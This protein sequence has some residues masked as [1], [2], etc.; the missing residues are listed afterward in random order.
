M[1]A[2]ARKL[3]QESSHLTFSAAMK[4]KKMFVIRLFDQHFEDVRSDNFKLNKEIERF[5]MSTISVGLLWVI[6]YDI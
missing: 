5:E 6:K 4:K 3:I 1:K 2:Q